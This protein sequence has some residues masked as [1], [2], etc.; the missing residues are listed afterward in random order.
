M[1]QHSEVVLLR[2]F[3]KSDPLVGQQRTKNV[4]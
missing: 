3:G 1:L 2:G 4:C